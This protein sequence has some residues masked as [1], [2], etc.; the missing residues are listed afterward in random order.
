MANISG[1]KAVSESSTFVIASDAVV[2][3]SP[4]GQLPGMGIFRKN[5]IYLVV[6]DQNG[7]WATIL[8]SQQTAKDIEAGIS[9]TL[10]DID[11]GSSES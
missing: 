4:S 7:R 9:Q 3:Y 11:R 5:Q 1:P 6:K 10:Q 2:D 8:L